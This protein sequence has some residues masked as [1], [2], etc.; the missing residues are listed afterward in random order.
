MKEN[1]SIDADRGV[2]W[3]GTVYTS[4]TVSY[5][6]ISSIKLAIPTETK[7]IRVNVLIA[8]CKCIARSYTISSPIY[9]GTSR[10]NTLFG[11]FGIHNVF[12]SLLP[13]LYFPLFL[14]NHFYSEGGLFARPFSPILIGFRIARVSVRT[15]YVNT[16]WWRRYVTLVRVCDLC[17]SCIC[18]NDDSASI[19]HIFSLNNVQYTCRTQHFPLTH[20][21]V[22]E[23][24]LILCMCLI[25]PNILFHTNT[26]AQTHA[27]ARVQWFPPWRWA[28]EQKENE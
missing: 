18:A 16:R 4:G 26:H 5:I 15:V 6:Y 2:V 24:L 17:A 1:I 23:S 12:L 9:L 22:P 3:C 19:F 7:N 25:A 27:H 11:I 13:V 20:T 14:P 10:R 21:Y 28:K 8:E